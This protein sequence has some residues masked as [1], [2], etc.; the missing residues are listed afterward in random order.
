MEAMGRGVVRKKGEGRGEELSREG[1][2]R[3]KSS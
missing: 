2:E 3:S 1:D